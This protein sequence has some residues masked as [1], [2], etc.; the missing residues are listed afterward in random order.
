MKLPIPQP[1]YFHIFVRFDP[2]KKNCSLQLESLCQQL[3]EKTEET[4]KLTIRTLDL[5]NEVQVLNR[6]HNNSLKVSNNSVMCSYA[7]NS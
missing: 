1:L 5:E 2:L 3:T 7:I 6:K 4:K